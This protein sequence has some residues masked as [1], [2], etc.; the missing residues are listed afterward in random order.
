M[1]SKAFYSP[2]EVA[3]VL[4]LHEVTVLR[5]LR[6]GKMPAGK[7]GRQWRVSH[8]ALEE[9]L[10]ARIGAQRQPPELPAPPPEGSAREVLEAAE[11][12]QRAVRQGP[13]PHLRPE[14]LRELRWAQRILRDVEVEL[15]EQEDVA[16]GRRD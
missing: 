14:E 6:E 11:R 7:I 8:A 15:L 1:E 13:A 5:L 4:N 12:L 3:E 10:G 2:A 9:M 16:D